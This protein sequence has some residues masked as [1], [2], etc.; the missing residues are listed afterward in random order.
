MHNF[1]RAVSE[2]LPQHTNGLWI[3]RLQGCAELTL[4][5]VAQV[6]GNIISTRFGRKDPRVEA[7]LNKSSTKCARTRFRA[8]HP[9]MNSRA[10]GGLSRNSSFA[11]W[12][13]SPETYDRGQFRPLFL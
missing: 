3:C 12:L 6:V 5:S 13:W 8:P 2:D 9:G 11:E 10:P 1:R 4:C 7:S